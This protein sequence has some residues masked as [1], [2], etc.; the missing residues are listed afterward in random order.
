MAA[1]VY[2][3]C[4]WPART[5]RLNG[6]IQCCNTGKGQSK[7]ALAF[8]IKSPN[9][10]EI[11]TLDIYSNISPFIFIQ[12]IRIAKVKCAHC[13][14]FLH[15]NFICCHEHSPENPHWELNLCQK[16]KRLQWGFH[17]VGVRRWKGVWR[18]HFEIQN[19]SQHHKSSPVDL[20]LTYVWGSLCD[21]G[22]EYYL[23]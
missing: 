9:V 5:I 16:E 15:T 13:R 1:C 17:A 2:A 6:W 20:W 4:D 12:Y 8:K 21:V 19:N 7:K 18:E 11:K 23:I 22:A 10:T 3:T 14:T